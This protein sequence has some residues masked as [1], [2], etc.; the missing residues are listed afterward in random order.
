MFPNHSCFPAIE[1]EHFLQEARVSSNLGKI[2]IIFFEERFSQTAV[3]SWRTLCWRFSPQLLLVMNLSTNSPLFLPAIV[4]GGD[5]DS[6]FQL[7]SQ[8][9]ERLLELG[10]V[11][12]SEVKLQNLDFFL[13]SVSRDKRSCLSERS[14]YQSAIIFS[15]A[16]SL[17]SLLV[18]IY[19]KLVFRHWFCTF[20]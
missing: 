5:E 8:L 1:G 2:K 17:I 3:A 20:Q 16:V 9:L 14:A 7:S 11:R 19:I 12:G 4:I 15:V 13:F 10:C 6:A 18:A